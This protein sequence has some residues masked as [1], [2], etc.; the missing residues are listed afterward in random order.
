MRNN[1]L[2][3]VALAALSGV[4]LCA[5]DIAGDWQGTLKTGAAEL[6]IVLNIAKQPDGSWK[7]TLFSIDQGTDGIPV[8]SLK[9]QGS[10]LKMTV[11]A[12]RGTYE[13]T[14]GTDGASIEGT[15]TQGKPLPLG[16]KRATKETAW[17]DPSPR[18]IQFVTVDKDVKLEVLPP[19]KGEPGK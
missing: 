1:P 13:G 2:W 18:T 12:I 16:L 6:R 9:L 5:Q 19:P 3:I 10:S 4:T 14:L 11:E 7:A 8:N 15:W 17:K